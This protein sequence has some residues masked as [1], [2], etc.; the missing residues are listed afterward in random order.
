MKL[1]PDPA[2]FVSCR[3][4]GTPKTAGALAKLL[5]RYKPRTVFGFRNQPMQSL[6]EVR[7]TDKVFVCFQ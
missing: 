6:Y 5:K 2:L 1:T 4:I 3:R 7:Y